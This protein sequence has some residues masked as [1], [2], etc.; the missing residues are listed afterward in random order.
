MQFNYALHV[1]AHELWAQTCRPV[2]A[3]QW[4]HVEGLFKVLLGFFCTCGDWRGALSIECAALCCCLP[5][6]CGLCSGRPGPGA[7]LQGQGWWRWGRARSSKVQVC[8]QHTWE[9]AMGWSLNAA[10][11][12]GAQAAA[13]SRQLIPGF[14]A[15]LLERAVSSRSPGWARRKAAGW[16]C[17]AGRALP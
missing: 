9:Q 17:A 8:L 7:S 10:L 12:W 2:Q 11:S 14:P 15:V 16:L 5:A 1:C 13:L 4:D 6:R 3:R